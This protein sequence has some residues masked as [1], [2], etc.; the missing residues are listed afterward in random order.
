MA[1]DYTAIPTHQV[2]RKDREVNDEAW[3][4]R[5]LHRAPMG[6]LATVQSEQPFINSNLFVYDEAAHAIYLHTAKVGRTRA[7]V[8][9]NARVC[10]SVTTMGRMLPAPEALEFSVE[11]AG[12]V[13]FGKAQLVDDPAKAAAAL[14]KLLDKYAPHLRPGRD[15]RPPIDEELKRT[16]VYHI[17][18]EAWSGKRKEVAENFPGAYRYEE[19]VMD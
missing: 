13:V 14:Q 11:Y 7:N 6:Y 5:L 19:I 2:T 1:R 15:Y 3:I 12:V 10:F 18:I 8:E 16:T 9:G 4:K 17:Q